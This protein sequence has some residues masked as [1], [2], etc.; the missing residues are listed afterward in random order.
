M[1]QPWLELEQPAVARWEAPLQVRSSQKDL[2]VSQ[3][4]RQQA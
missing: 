2:P 1:H 4:E 3:A